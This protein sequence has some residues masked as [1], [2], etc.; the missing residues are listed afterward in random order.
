LLPFFRMRRFRRMQPL[1]YGLA[2]ILSL[3]AISGLSGC[4]TGSGYFG[5]ASQNYTIN[6]IGTATQGGATLQH[7]ISVALT[8]Q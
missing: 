7:S 3:A 1:T 5:Q 4:G 2:L 6:I 8:V